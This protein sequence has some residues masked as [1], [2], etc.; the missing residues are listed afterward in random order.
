MLNRM[1]PSNIIVPLHAEI[2]I[3]D[4]KAILNKKY[5]QPVIIVSTNI[6]EESLTIDYIDTVVD[7]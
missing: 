6:A 3:E 4:Q 2:P 5:K 7:R 1:L